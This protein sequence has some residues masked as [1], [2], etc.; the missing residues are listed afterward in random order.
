MSQKVATKSYELYMQ[1]NPGSKMTKQEYD[2]KYHPKQHGESKPPEALKP[3]TAPVQA[4]PP[5]PVEKAKP[6]P[7]IKP[8]RQT[9]S[10][11]QNEKNTVHEESVPVD[12]SFPVNNKRI[13]K[14]KGFNALLDYAGQGKL[15]SA[16]DASTLIHHLGWNE[17][18]FAQHLFQNLGKTT[19]MDQIKYFEDL[20]V[21]PHS[22]VKRQIQ[23]HDLGK[24]VPPKLHEHYGINS[25]AN[26]PVEP[27]KARMMKLLGDIEALEADLEDKEIA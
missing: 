22:Y 12:N 25:G 26:D 1:E 5:K 17:Q 15:Q 7:P 11:L 10:P 3:P 13:D 8:S 19:N 18:D 2:A 23:Y 4:K 6:M 9:Q 24:H 14:T 16:K 21:L 20:G 27:K